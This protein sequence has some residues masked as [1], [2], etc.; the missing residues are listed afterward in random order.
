MQKQ[1][2]SSSISLPRLGE[3][4]A[5]LA[6]LA[7]CLVCYLPAIN[8][9]GYYW[10]DWPTMWFL[11][12][13]GPSSFLHGFAED[14]PFLAWIYMTTTSLLGDSILKWQ[15]FGVFTRWLAATSLW[16][17]L[18]ALWPRYNSLAIWASLLFA[19]Y[20]GF[21]QQYISVTYSNAFLVFSLFLV[22]LGTMLHA[23]RNPR[24]FWPLYGVSLLLA[25]ASL[26][27][28]EYFFGLELARPILLWIAL[29]PSQSQRGAA[30]SPPPPWRKIALG[31]LPY[32]L[33]V[34]VFVI[35]HTQFHDTP[36]AQIILFE[37]LASQPL[38]TIG[39]TMLTIAQDFLEL[40]FV[41]WLRAFDFRPLAGFDPGV[42]RNFF[43]IAAIAAL[44]SFAYLVWMKSGEIRANNNPGKTSWPYKSWGLQATLLGFIIF[45]LAGWPV[46]LTNLHFELLFPWDR[47]AL[48][49]MTATAILT[50][51]LLALV[52]PRRWVGMLLLAVLVGISAGN[53]Y[54]LRQFYR[55][56]WLVQRNFFWQIAW[57]IP[58]LQAGTALVTSQLPFTYFSDNSLTAPLNWIYRPENRS[59]Q[60]SFA[61]IDM[62]ARLGK[63]LPSLHP[64]TP[65]AIQ[66]RL[67]NFQGSLSQAVVLFYDPPRC[68]KV[69][70]PSIDRFLPIKP[71]YIN[72]ALQ[73]SKV[74][75][76]NPQPGAALQTLANLLG[77]EPDHGWCYY[78]QKADLAR[79]FGNWPA[80]AEAAD[81][82]LRLPKE[83]SSKNI[84]ELLPFIEAYAHTRQWQKAL[85]LSWQTFQ[86]WDKMQYIL[87]DVW[88][89][90]AASKPDEQGQAAIEEIWSQLNCPLPRP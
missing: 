10:D 68:L 24:R 52:S 23:Y 60:M 35:W 55:Q 26:F 44:S 54:Q 2:S 73:L 72:E 1:P 12:A 3:W 50:A 61:V 8:R 20:P 82:A 65:L 25:G 21:M 36:R 66:Y 48:M 87:C 90:V 89:S 76:I 41:A 86:T 80:A 37:Q 69:I 29:A 84:S 30:P 62:Q 34:M 47:F 67:A 63:S 22:S 85:E 57:R 74:E 40:N 56:D 19:V 6:L 16:W 58:D 18:R 28:S 81:Q 79:Q 17:T 39:F 78:F 27:I 7:I 11:H 33:L 71:T 51:G 64:D 5:P 45:L 75:L 46:W 31:W 9:L 83:L 14:R 59:T 88:T 77:P 53:Q 43:I 38:A 13:W 4:S 32:L 15:L 49:T 70:D 42:M